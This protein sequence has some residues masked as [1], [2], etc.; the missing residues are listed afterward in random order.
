MMG[1]GKRLLVVGDEERGGCPLV[2]QLELHYFTVVA[3]ADGL[4]AL[5]ELHRRHFDAVITDLQIP[6]LDGLDLLCQ[7]RLVWPQLPIILLSGNLSGIVWPA[8]AQGAFACL[9]KPVDTEK[10]IHVLSQAILHTDDPRSNQVDMLSN[11]P[12]AQRCLAL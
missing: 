6:Y 11:M 9:P 5:R 3:V 10:L 1:Y 12:E 7:C 4:Q 8:M 2:G